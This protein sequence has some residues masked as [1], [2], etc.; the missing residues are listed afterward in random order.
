MFSVCLIIFALFAYQASAYNLAPKRVMIAS[1][2]KLREPLPRLWIPL[3][4]RG[5]FVPPTASSLMA[6]KREDE[7]AYFETDVSCM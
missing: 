3:S 7:E 1:V 5:A 2:S 4:S 6:I